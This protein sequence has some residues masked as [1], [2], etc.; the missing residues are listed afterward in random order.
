MEEETRMGVVHRQVADADAATWNYATVSVKEYDEGNASRGATRRI[1]IG[2]DE[3]AA[4]F[5]VRY[6][7]IPAGGHSSLEQH[8]HQHGVV[9]VHGHGRV[10]LG[11]RWTEIG[12]GDAVYVEP[13]ELHQFQADGD[14]P[15]GFIC[16][17]P[18]WA[19][20]QIGPVADEAASQPGR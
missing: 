15:L 1:L 18:A 19:K 16:V 14:Q 13:D 2:R 17:I 4:D 12:E 9:I 3:G 7:T 8:R 20:A 11:D 6:F 5:I 10:L